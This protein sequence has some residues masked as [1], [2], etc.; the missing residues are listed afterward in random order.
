[1]P[2]TAIAATRPTA[3]ESRAGRSSPR[4]SLSGSVGAVDAPGSSGSCRAA[5]TAAAAATPPS[6]E[7]VG[8]SDGVDAGGSSS[9]ASGGKGVVGVGG[10]SGINSGSG[11]ISARS[12]TPETANAGGMPMD[13][14]QPRPQQDDED[15]PQSGVNNDGSS[16]LVVD[17]SDDSPVADA[18]A[19]HAAQGSVPGSA[20]GGIEREEVG[21]ATTPASSSASH[22]ANPS[23]AAPQST[24]A[25]TEKGEGARGGSGSSSGGGSGSTSNHL[26]KGRCSTVYTD[27]NI[28]IGD[29]GVLV[30][31]DGSKDTLKRRRREGEPAESSGKGAE[32]KPSPAVQVLG[33]RG[34]PGPDLAPF[35]R[36]TALPARK[37]GGGKG[38]RDGGKLSAIAVGLRRMGASGARTASEASAAEVMADRFSIGNATQEVRCLLCYSPSTRTQIYILYQHRGSQSVLYSRIK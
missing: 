3:D 2:L 31:K 23:L 10:T 29:D 17:I 38:G 34:V 25:S 33:L 7:N 24:S 37:D 18:S 11:D 13:V 1:M 8:V 12:A 27:L 20:D 26:G 9:V 35:F 16:E 15:L 28:E 6:N 5:A 22:A 4:T 32:K 30:E 21:K 19:P 14:D 36:G